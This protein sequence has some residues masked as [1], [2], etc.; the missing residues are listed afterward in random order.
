MDIRS[1]RW[2]LTLGQIA[3]RLGEPTHRVKYAIERHQIEPIRRAGIIRMFSPDQLAQIEAALRRTH[4][5]GD[6]N[7]CR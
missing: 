4:L 5:K 2:L 7:G 6:H 3:R 1:E